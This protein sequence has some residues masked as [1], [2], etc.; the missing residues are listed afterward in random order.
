MK[1]MIEVVTLLDLR[2]EAED[3]AELAELERMDGLRGEL[4]KVT[5]TELADE[6]AARA[7]FLRSR[8]MFA[9]EDLE[10]AERDLLFVLDRLETRARLLALDERLG[11]VSAADAKRRLSNL[12]HLAFAARRDYAKL[13][14]ACDDHFPSRPAPQGK[15]A[16]RRELEEIE[17]FLAQK[18]AQSTGTDGK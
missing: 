1:T 12:E 4:R 5:A 2:Q 7:T 9:A 8:P 18:R 3:E 17:R 14:E 16:R 10:K 11:N 15:E 6:L 13:V